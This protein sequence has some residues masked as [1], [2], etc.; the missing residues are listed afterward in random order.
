MSYEIEK[1][2]KNILY[3]LAVVLL[4][5]VVANVMI[6]CGQNMSMY[7]ISYT[8]YGSISELTNA[9]TFFYVLSQRAKQFLVIILLYKVFSG[10]LVFRTI[11]SGLLFI[12]GFAASCQ[13]YYLGMQGVLW[14]LVCIFPH[15][16]VY[17]WLIF[18]M[19]RYQQYGRD[20]KQVFLYFGLII[21][22]F[23]V[24]VLSESIISSFLLKIFLQYIG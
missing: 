2:R 6:R 20:S 13:L 22:C 5:S 15:Y 8:D 24:G 17:C 21:S 10:P 23:I 1:L 9:Q 4:G 11:I 19:Y 7:C 14:L 18:H 12:F 3:F 16:F